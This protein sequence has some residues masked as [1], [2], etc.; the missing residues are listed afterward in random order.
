MRYRFLDL[1]RVGIYGFSGGGFSST[2]AILRYPDFFKVA[3]SG[4]GNHDNRS[5]RFEW[6]EKYQGRY[7]RD[8]VTGRDNFENQAN[9]LLAGNLKGRLLLFHGDMDTNVHPSMTLRLVDA[10]IKANKDFDMLIIPDAGHSTSPYL[11]KK[12][13]DY[14][15]RWLLGAEPPRDYRMIT[16]DDDSC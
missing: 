13:W 12:G 7:Q 14:F 10:L 6:G 8:S 16:C 5:Y 15:V 4:A 3:V 1:D 9:Y 2:D 11:T